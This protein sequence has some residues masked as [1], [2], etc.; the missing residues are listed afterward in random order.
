MRFRRFFSLSG[1]DGAETTDRSQPDSVIESSAL[2]DDTQQVRVALGQLGEKQRAAIVLRHFHGLTYNALSDVLG[3][4]H[5]AVESL[6]FRARARLR[7]VLVE[8]RKKKMD[9]QDRGLSGVQQT[10]K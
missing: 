6:L 4:S 3:V 1:Q 2:G 9:P 7:A 5:S 10:G 8:A